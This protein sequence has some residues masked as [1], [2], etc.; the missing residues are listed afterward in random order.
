MVRKDAAL[1]IALTLIASE[2]CAAPTYGTDMLKRGKVAI[3]YQNNIVF[4][5][6]LSDSYGYIKSDQHFFDISY[7]VYDWLSVCGKAGMADLIQKGGGHPKVSYGYGFAG[8]YGFR[9]RAYN[10]TKEKIRI[11]LGF[12]HISVH[13]V[14]S[15]WNSDKYESVLDD[16]QASLAGSKDIGAIT[17]YVGIKFSKFDLVYKV[18]EMDRKRRPPE[19]FV[20]LVTGITVRFRDDLSARV[21]AH[22]FDETALSTGAYYTY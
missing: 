18:N 11:V 22:F 17:P 21:E 4:R 16:W 12:H 2:A 10:N 6:D 20:G 7:G 3:G 8:G 15:S 13:P 9:I 1:V 5:H 14:D 19:N